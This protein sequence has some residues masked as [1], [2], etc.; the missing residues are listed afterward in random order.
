MEGAQGFGLQ[1]GASAFCVDIVQN[2]EDDSR[3]APK[4]RVHFMGIHK[5]PQYISK[6]EYGKR[7]IKFFENYSHIPMIRKNFVKMEEA[8][9]PIFF[10]LETR[11]SHRLNHALVASE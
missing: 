11:Q 4:D 8:R 1:G 7:F 3:V 10:W 5:V 9:L 2:F 6:E